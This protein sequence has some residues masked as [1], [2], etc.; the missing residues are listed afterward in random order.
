MKTLFLGIP[1]RICVLRNPVKLSLNRYNVNWKETELLKQFFATA[2]CNGSLTVPAPALAVLRKL[3]Q[4]GRSHRFAQ[5]PILCHGLCEF[6]ICFFI[7]KSMKLLQEFNFIVEK[8][9]RAKRYIII[10]R[11]FSSIW[12]W[13]FFIIFFQKKLPAQKQ[14][15]KEVLES[16][17]VALLKKPVSQVQVIGIHMRAAELSS[18]S[19][20]VQE[21]RLG[22]VKTLT[23]L[24]IY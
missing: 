24:K 10:L 3:W 2:A 22:K 11:K 21:C 14:T 9:Q 15:I 12:F 18:T 13:F 1:S 7:Q 23:V 4:P 17:Q 19:Y 5:S 8:V 20:I 6:C 16:I